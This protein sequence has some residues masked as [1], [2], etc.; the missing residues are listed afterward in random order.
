MFT[1]IR[2]PRNRI[3][4]D[5]ERID[6]TMSYIEGPKVRDWSQNYHSHNYNE[7]KEKWTVNWAQFKQELNNQF[8]DKARQDKAQE[9]FERIQQGPNEKAADFFTHFKICIDTAGYA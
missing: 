5:S 6:V 4:T 2:D 7:E 1:Y 8:L 9:E 3:K